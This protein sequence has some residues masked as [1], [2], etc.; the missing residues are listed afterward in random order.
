MNLQEAEKKI[1]FLQEVLSVTYITL[2]PMAK[3]YAHEHPEGR[4]TEMIVE[5][6]HNIRIALG[7]ELDDSP[8]ESTIPDFTRKR[9]EL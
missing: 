8:I 6:E 4:N 2:M 7:L 9:I 3:G 5:N 1:R